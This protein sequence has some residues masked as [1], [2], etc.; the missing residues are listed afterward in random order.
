M[1]EKKTPKRRKMRFM[2]HSPTPEEDDEHEFEPGSTRR[3]DKSLTMLTRSVV[4]MLR[5]TP[6]GVLYLRDVSST[7]SN[8]QKRRIYDV[9][10]VL[11]GI[12]LV[13][14]QVKNHIKWIGEEVT[15]QSCLGT[16][17]KIGEH[18]RTRRNLELREALIDKQLKAIRQSSHMLREDSATGSFLYVTSDDLTSV[19]GDNRTLLT[20]NEERLARL[21]QPPVVQCTSW[22]IPY[23]GN[24]R[25]L[26]VKSR[27]KGAPLT[28][29]V[30]KEPAGACY[31]RPSR[32]PAVLRA[33][34][35][36]RYVKLAEQ[37]HEPE[38]HDARDGSE[39]QEPGER[40]YDESDEEEY[41]RV[42]QRERFARI[43]LDTS[44]D[45]HH[46]LYRPNGWKK[47]KS[48]TRGLLIPFLVIK[49]RFYGRFTFALK[50]NEG[51]FDLFG[52]GRI[53]NHQRANE[54][55]SQQPAMEVVHVADV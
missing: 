6:D 18:M 13:K 30:L 7:L 21:R 54:R 33:N 43:L 4:K 31:T 38:E 29:M 10:N 34:A 52:Y 55:T 36:Q 17:R 41:T 20:L 51:V 35:E 39:W 26:W 16:A 48:E 23:G 45:A 5:E 9:T 40:E 11:E 19:F 44:P 12:G 15:T 3:F 37:N 47:K 28:L 24:T 53:S 1:D 22:T 25:Q 42:R 32:R 14:K 50:P 27:P 2:N 49:P 46:S 8:R